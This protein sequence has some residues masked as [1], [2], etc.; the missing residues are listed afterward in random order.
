MI[1]NIVKIDSKIGSF[2]LK[3]DLLISE[4]INCLF[5]PSGSGKT[6][7]VNC[8]AG[9]IKPTNSLIKINNIILSNSKNNFF[10]PIHKRRIGYVFQ[11]SR[12][13]PHLNV[14]Q[15]LLYGKKIRKF[16]TERFFFEDIV[17]LLELEE[18]INRYPYNLSG[19]EKQRVSI[20]RA[21]LSQP[22]III[23]DEPLASLDQKRKNELL[24]YILRVNKKYKI[25]IVYVSHSLFEIF[26]LGKNINF[27]NEGQLT[28]S[29]NKE[30][31]ISYYNNNI[32]NEFENSFLK[33]KVSKIIKEDG[34]SEI[35]IGNRKLLIFTNSLKLNS[36]VLLKINSSD[37]IISKYQP[38][39]QSS[40]NFLKVKIQDIFEEKYLICLVLRFGGN[41]IKA[42]I[43]KMS[44]K[45][46][47][48]KKE[49]TC[50]ASIK[51]I[52][53]NDFLDISLI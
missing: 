41:I 20:G 48:M 36:N 38:K 50:Y 26:L 39:N 35:L 2:H 19:G 52:N 28:F 53:I 21:M 43:T 1:D 18:V 14:K 34:L 12:L 22:D 15:N 3:I 37:I 9:L 11:D 10:L 49:D 42:H 8:I 7:I 27:I 6:S 17:K 4:G 44:F 40:L 13:F 30:R 23:M 31:A 29:G 5:G 46:L 47:K 24:Q 45:L 16:L 51:A 32:G 33:G 25:P